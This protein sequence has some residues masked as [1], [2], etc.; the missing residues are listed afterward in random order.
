MPGHVFFASFPPEAIAKKGYAGL[1]YARFVTNASCG[2]F[3]LFDDLRDL[4]GRARNI[5]IVGAKDRPGS[6]V[7]HVGRYLLNAGFNIMPVHPV[8]RQA[9][10]IPTVRNITELPSRGFQPD[11]ICLF[12]APQYCAEHA[13]ETLS[14][15]RLP[16]IFWMQEGIRSPEAGMLM[17]GAGVKVVEDRCLQT[18]HAALFDESSSVFA[19]RMCGKCC[20]GRGGIVVG[21]RDLPRLCAHFNLPAEEVLARYTENLGGKP[22]LKCGEDG[23]C[24]F[25]RAGKGCSIHPARPAVCRAWPFFRG[26]LVDEV[27]FAMAGEDCPG[28]AKQTTHAEFARE[29]YR[30]LKEY[31][32]LADD[33]LHEGRALVVKEEELPPLNRG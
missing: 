9:W 5:A 22:T 33:I 1:H 4:L 13:R 8:R 27:S 17:A 29:G 3:M 14:L 30:Y 18:V 21:P 24:L 16:L 31:K 12:R 2:V 15:P 7:D 6:P 20:E 32:L 25:F 10:G 19:C 23:F 26:N 28:I 11:I